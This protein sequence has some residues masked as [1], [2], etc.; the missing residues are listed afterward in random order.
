M[1]GTESHGHSTRVSRIP[2]DDSPRYL[3]REEIE[4]PYEFLTSRERKSSNSWRKAP[5]IRMWRQFLL[6]VLPPV[7]CYR[8]HI[9]RE[10]NLHSL[11]DPIL[12]AV[13][14]G[15]IARHAAARRLPAVQS[16]HGI[17]V[18]ILR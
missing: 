4:D 10:L 12:Y 13:R 15:V 18:M 1:K 6:S 2:A 9:F 11:A 17:L 7:V 14:K 5:P 16:D 3:Q 8:R